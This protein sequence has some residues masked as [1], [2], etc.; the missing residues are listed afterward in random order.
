MAKSS[1]DSLIGSIVK[2]LID[3]VVDISKDLQTNITEESEEK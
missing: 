1:S 2:F 3:L